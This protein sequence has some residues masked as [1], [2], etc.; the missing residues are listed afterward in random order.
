MNVAVNPSLCRC[1][2]IGPNVT[3]SPVP[4]AIGQAAAFATRES[5]LA[6]ALG[7]QVVRQT[8][9]AVR[10]AHRAAVEMA[11]LIAAGHL[12]SDSGAAIRA[13]AGPE[14]PP[15]SSL[16]SRDTTRSRSNRR[17]NSINPLRAHSDRGRHAAQAGWVLGMISNALL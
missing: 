16:N 10:A 15:N 2:W 13:A 9:D 1:R 14:Y 12:Q 7:P 3:R 4:G 11:R 17:S 8:D 5:A 6:A